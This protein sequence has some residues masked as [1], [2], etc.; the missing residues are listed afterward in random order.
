MPYHSNLSFTVKRKRQKLTEYRSYNSAVFSINTFG[1]AI[2]YQ[3][4]QC[5]QIQS[6]RFV[7][8]YCYLLAIYRT[9]KQLLYKLLSKKTNIS[10]NSSDLL[11]S[12]QQFESNQTRGVGTECAGTK[13]LCLSKL[14]KLHIEVN[15][16]EKRLFKWIVHQYI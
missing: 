3:R 15:K 10:K 12:N 7:N 11:V 6:Q 13:Q 9:Y 2:L 1:A 4:I 8:F 16:N 5:Q 14:T